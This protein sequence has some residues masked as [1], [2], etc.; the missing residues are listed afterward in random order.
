MNHQPTRVESRL[1]AYMSCTG[2]QP[3]GIYRVCWH[4]RVQVQVFILYVSYCA[5]PLSP[6]AVCNGCACATIDAI[7][8]LA[9]SIHFHK[10][11]IYN[12]SS[13]WKSY[14]AVYHTSG[15]VY[16]ASC[17]LSL[18][19]MTNWL[20][21]YRLYTCLLNTIHYSL[22]RTRISWFISA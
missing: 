6:T 2:Q 14:G 8:A 5:C 16:T 11:S 20:Y 13:V 3:V 10:Y 19:P 7:I 15:V 1:L 17:V 21:L 12:Y 22:L 4:F 18:Y 9:Q